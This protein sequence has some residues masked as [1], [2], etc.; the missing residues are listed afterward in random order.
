MLSAAIGR[1]IGLLV[2]RQGKVRMAIVGT[3]TSLLIP[4]LPVLAESGRMLRGWRLLHTHLGAAPI[5]REDLLDMLFLR[6]DALILLN[7]AENG[8][9]LLWQSA[10]LNAGKRKPGEDPWTIEPPRPWHQASWDFSARIASLEAEFAQ[11]GNAR[12]AA[13]SAKAVLVSIGPESAALQEERLAELAELAESAAIAPVGKLVQ[14]SSHQGA[15]LLLGKG[16]LAELEIMALDGGADLLIFDGEL[17]PA[18]LGNLAEATQRKVI[19]RTQLILDIFARRATSKAGKLQVEMAQLAYAQPRLAGASKALDRLAG[20]PGGR[21]PGEAKLEMDRRKI[22]D[23]LAFLRKQLQTLRGQRR[24]TRLRRTRNGIPQ[25]ALIGYTNAGKSSLLNKITASEVLEENQLFAT[26]DPATRRIRF[27]SEKEII[28]S[29]TV[30]FIRNL[31][32]ELQEA[33]RATLEELESAA[34]LL[35]VVDISQPDFIARM[36]SVATILEDLGYAEKPMLLVFNKA[37]KLAP[38]ERQDLAA[39]W[40]AAFFVSAATGSGLE[41]LLNA[42]FTKLSPGKRP[43]GDSRRT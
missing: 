24:L 1:Q 2:D 11:N 32:R 43:G 15:K 19:D 4:E 17:S 42:V 33:F 27:P 8:E 25:A 26:L 21:G 10:M 3:A 30:G 7:A 12:Y 38:E 41:N 6:L 20:G 16:K 35:H 36:D 18:Q 34:L 31:P 13:A 22:R 39:A 9:P 29:D 23:R 28:L 37:D 14:R 5:S 40:P